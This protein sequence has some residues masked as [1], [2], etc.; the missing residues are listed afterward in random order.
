MR[1]DHVAPV[2]DVVAE[3]G[4]SHRHFID[5]FRSSVGLAPKLFCRVRR[6]RRAVARL[7]AGPG[8]DTEVALE[9]GY[10]DQAHLIRD[11]REFAGITPGECRRRG[12]RRPGHVPS[13]R[14]GR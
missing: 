2:G 13:R 7:S 4:Y 10:S 8:S 3:T 1:G 9:A 11:F 6:F 5:L 14:P 12:T